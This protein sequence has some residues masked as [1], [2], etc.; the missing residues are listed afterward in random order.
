MVKTA[1]INKVNGNIINKEV[2]IAKCCIGYL[3]QLY[4]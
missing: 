1:S 4:E 2:E 3:E